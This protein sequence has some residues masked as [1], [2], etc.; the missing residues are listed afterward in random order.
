MDRICVLYKL[1]GSWLKFQAPGITLTLSLGIGLLVFN[2]LN[3]VESVFSIRI[4]AAT[5][6]DK[7]KNSIGLI[8]FCVAFS[9][10]C[11]QTFYLLPSL[12]LRAAAI[13]AGN[14]IYTLMHTSCMFLLKR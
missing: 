9:I 2:K 1:Y 13:I 5:L 7:N 6:F 14:K 10:L 8:A 12:D 4:L 11:I 3:K